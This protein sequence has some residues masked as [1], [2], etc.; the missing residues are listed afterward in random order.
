MKQTWRGPGLACIATLTALCSLTTPAEAGWF[1]KQSDEPKASSKPAT[2]TTVPV[3]P[4]AAVP[5]GPPPGMP[6]SGPTVT[7]YAEIKDGTATWVVIEQSLMGGETQAQCTA[8][9]GGTMPGIVPD[10]TASF[11]RVHGATLPGQPLADKLQIMLTSNVAPEKSNI[12][13]LVDDKKAE[14][15][16]AARNYMRGATIDITDVKAFEQG[17]KKGKKTALQFDDNKLE[18]PA[19]V[20]FELSEKLDSCVAD[21]EKKLAKAAEEAKKAAPTPAKK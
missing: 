3:T 18:I 16:I 4:P 13:V 8:A 9:H 12:G 10:V 5:A 7:N 17:L 1:D 11:I 20:L 2:P 14:T 21:Q 6:T 15:Q 19:S